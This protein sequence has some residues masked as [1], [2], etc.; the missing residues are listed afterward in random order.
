MKH[1]IEMQDEALEDDELER[2]SGGWELR[3]VLV[4][5]YQTGGAGQDD[6]PPP[7][8]ATLAERVYEGR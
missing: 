3:N 8:T 2:I 4:T 6:G 1:E 7:T 5:S